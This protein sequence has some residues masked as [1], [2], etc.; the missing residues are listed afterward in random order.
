MK[1]YFAGNTIVREREN[2]ILNLIQRRLLS[3]Y[4]ICDEKDSFAQRYSLNEIIV[5][6]RKD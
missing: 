6:K 1:I 5:F 4:Y 2:M 3:Y